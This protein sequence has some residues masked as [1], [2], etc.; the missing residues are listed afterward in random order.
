[1]CKVLA[2][3]YKLYWYVV[4]TNSKQLVI[5]DRVGRSRQGM[6]DIHL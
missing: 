4:W 1:M 3:K 6:K 5:S 2:E